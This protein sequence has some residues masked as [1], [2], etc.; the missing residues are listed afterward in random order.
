M[1]I[2]AGRDALKTNTVFREFLKS[3]PAVP[4]HAARVPVAAKPRG[5]GSQRHNG[6]GAAIAAAAA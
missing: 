1:L 6:A 5:P 3:L 4:P 2:D